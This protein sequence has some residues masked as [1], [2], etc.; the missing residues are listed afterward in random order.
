MYF[1]FIL[2][3]PE[4]FSGSLPSLQYVI[5]LGLHWQARSKVIAINYKL[6]YLFLAIVPQRV[7]FYRTETQM[8]KLK[9]AFISKFLTFYR[10]DKS[11]KGCKL[12]SDSFFFNFC[13][14]IT[15][16]YDRFF[17]LTLHVVRY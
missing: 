7:T 15:F 1:F 8:N 4:Y 9:L 16:V 10:N 2:S 3:L 11:H 13:N 6:I 17:Y 14:T 5:C 12:V